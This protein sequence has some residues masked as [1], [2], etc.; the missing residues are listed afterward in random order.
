MKITKLELSHFRGAQS[1]NLDL[2]ERLNV[3]VG[4]NGSGKSSVLDAVAILLSWMVSTI[5]HAG[6]S[7][8]HISE[9][10]IQNGK[11]TANL[12]VTCKFRGQ[13]FSWNLAKTR[14]G[15]SKGDVTS[16]F[17]ALSEVAKKLQA[18]ITENDEKVNLPLMAYYPVTRAVLDIPLRIRG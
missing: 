5:K 8:R 9:I 10:D 17:I 6:T 2:H 7:G 13:Y 11:S 18:E 4:V 1:L 12:D 15:Y 16:V 3:L 14:E